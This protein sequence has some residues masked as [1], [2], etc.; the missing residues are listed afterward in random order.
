MQGEA[1]GS[2][3]AIGVFDGVHRGHQVVLATVTE[4]ARAMGVAS[5]VVTFDPLPVRVVAPE[6]AVGQIETLARRLARLASL[7]IDEVRVI[8]FDEDAAA[9]TAAAFVARVVVGEL[10]AR[11]VVVGADFRFGH[12]REGDVTLLRELG[13]HH[14]FD[15]IDVAAVGTTER[16]SSTAARRAVE[17][18]DLEGAQ[19]ILGHPVVLDG[20]VVRGDA[21]GA[22]LGFPTANV[23]LAPEVVR[24]G[25]GIYAG[26]ARTAAGDWYAAA[27][28]IGRRPQFYESGAVLVE[29]HLLD[30]AGTLYDQPLTV[31][32]LA[33]LR[34]E[35]RFDSTEALVAQIA[36]DV[37]ETRRRYWPFSS[38]PDL[39]LGFSLGW[40]R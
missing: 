26:A 13:A 6:R 22:T 14:G 21:R 17:A 19:A 27:V 24:A 29:A 9:E 4:T 18:G 11:T 25:E 20:T 36:A 7:G 28:S 2:V 10:A 5:A 31:V 33:H 3:V 23:A 39:L 37:E 35:E 1:R 34:G 15:V 40:R 32:L 38:E 8:D 30:F 16:Y 12:G